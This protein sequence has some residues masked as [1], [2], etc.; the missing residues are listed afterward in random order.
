MTSYSIVAVNSTAGAGRAP[1][2]FKLYASNNGTTWIT[3]QT[4]KGATYT[5]QIYN[6]TALSTNTTP[7]LYFA[8]VINQIIGSGTTS[9]I[10]QIAEI[11]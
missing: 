10:T 7:Y 2:N 8:F 5:N 1:K 4:I 3:L 11:F 6:N 9:G